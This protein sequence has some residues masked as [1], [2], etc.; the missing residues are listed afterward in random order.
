MK[1]GL[2]K[3]IFA[4]KTL[5]QKNLVKHLKKTTL[6]LANKKVNELP[7]YYEAAHFE[8]GAPFITIGVAKDI[9]RIFKM[10]RVKGNGG[11][12]EKGKII[13]INKKLVAFGNLTLN[14]QGQYEFQ[15]EQGFL[16]QQQLKA[17]INSI[18]ILKQTIGQNF[19]IT[20]GGMPVESAEENTKQETLE[21][22]SARPE[23]STK[24]ETFNSTP[25]WIAEKAKMKT[26]L[27]KMKGNLEQLSAKLG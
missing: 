16:K 11:K 25:E 1:N 8:D 24:K 21:E 18:T 22:T 6:A 26:T 23:A 27:L 2:N 4:D 13:K 5:L 19:V 7:F 17:S 9:H 12:D 10:E 14:Q 3:K 15:I 20:K